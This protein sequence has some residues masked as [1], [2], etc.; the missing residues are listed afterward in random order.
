M[1]E[2]QPAY[3]NLKE[4]T[5]EFARQ[6]DLVTEQ[7]ASAYLR[8]KI[9]KEEKAFEEKRIQLAESKAKLKSLKAALKAL[10]PKQKKQ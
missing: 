7:D 6:A 9:A 2:E 5:D 3:T 10:E 1:S 4:K 8:D